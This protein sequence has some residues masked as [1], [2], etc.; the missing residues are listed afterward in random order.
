[1]DCTLPVDATTDGHA[2]QFAG[3]AVGGP[4]LQHV[5]RD[6]GF[7]ALVISVFDYAV[8][9]AGVEVPVGQQFTADFH[10]NATGLGLFRDIRAQV[11]VANHQPV[12]DGVVLQVNFE[13]RDGGVQAA[14][15]VI[16]LEPDFVVVAFARVQQV[17]AGGAI[18]LRLEDAGVAGVDRVVGGQVVDHP[19]VRRD[20]AV[21]P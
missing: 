3:Q 4:D 21:D 13:Q 9:I 11:V 7:D 2:V 19:G 5:G 14:V 17:A 20:L 12:G 8:A 18:G 10:V 1:M 16:T 6:D 15:I